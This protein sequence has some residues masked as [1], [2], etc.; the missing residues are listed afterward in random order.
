MTCNSSN[1]CSECQTGFFLRVIDGSCVA[2]DKITEIKEGIF[3]VDCVENCEICAGKSDCLLCKSGYFLKSR[4]SCVPIKKLTPSLSFSSSLMILLLDFQSPTQLFVN[5]ISADSKQ[6]LNII[7][8]GFSP[9]EFTYSVGRNSSSVIYLILN[10]R[11]T[12]PKDTII[13]LFVNQ[14]SWMTS[15]EEV[16]DVYNFNL[17]YPEEFS[18]CQTG[19]YLE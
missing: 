12:V 17:T 3:C 10:Y 15:L 11:R 14:R 2:C 19:I 4:E 1:D 9:Q 13:Q 8:S 7:V 18:P 5:E 6:Y 16:L